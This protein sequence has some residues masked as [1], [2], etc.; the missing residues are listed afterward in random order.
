MARKRGYA[1]YYEYRALYDSGRIPPGGTPLRKGER[2]AARGHGAGQ[3]RAFRRFIRAGDLLVCDVRAAVATYDAGRQLYG[4]VRKQVIPLLG[5][6]R[7]VREFE[8]RRISK[9]GLA[10]LIA[11]EEQVGVQ[12]SPAPSLDQRRLA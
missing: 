4:L 12:F 9:A 3:E 11:F 7:R 10:A 8:L 6:R 1:S 5:S 2:G